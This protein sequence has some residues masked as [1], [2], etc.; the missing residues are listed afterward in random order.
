[1]TD[2]Y[3]KKAEVLLEAL[4]YMRRFQ[5]QTVVIKYGGAAQLEPKLKAAFARDITVLQY[6][7][8]HPVVVHGGGPQ[9]GKVLAQMDIPT[10]FVEGQRVTD[11]RTMDVVEMVLA[12]KINKEIVSLINTAGGTA[13]GLSGKDGRLL[14]AR[15]LQFYKPR[16]DEPPEIIDIG[17][18]GEVVAVNAA[19]IRTLQAEH[20]IPVIAPVGVGDAGETYNINADNVAG[21]V[22]RAMQAAKLILLTD[23]A[24]VLDENQQL[25]SSLDRDRALVMMDEGTIKGGMIPKVNCCLEAVTGGVGKAHILDGRRLHSVLLEIFTDTGI[26]TEIVG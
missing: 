19:L 9:I 24:G 20:F 1:M 8:I 6:L 13:V 22:A 15:K 10:R 17:L 2:E 18:V 3:I 5:G 7:G 14:T 16:E 11:E 26:G 23:V 4:P 21:A 25:V 12:G